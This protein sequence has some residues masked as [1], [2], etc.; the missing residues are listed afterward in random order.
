MSLEYFLVEAS[1]QLKN[2]LLFH[3]QKILIREYNFIIN[4][5]SGRLN[6]IFTD[7]KFCYFILLYIRRYLLKVIIRVK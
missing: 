6:I 1:G 3:I 2:Y 4:K 5:I 7:K